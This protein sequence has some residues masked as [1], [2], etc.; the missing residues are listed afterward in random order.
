MSIDFRGVDQYPVV[1]DNNANFRPK[2]VGPCNPNK[3]YVHKG[4]ETSA[5]F[6]LFASS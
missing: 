2:H 3:D 1:S 6:R 5:M 4:W